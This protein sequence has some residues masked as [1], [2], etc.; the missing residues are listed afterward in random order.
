MSV[1]VPL[2]EIRRVRRLSGESEGSVF[3]DLDFQEALE[4]YPL[5]DSSGVD[6][7][8]ADWL[9][10]WDVFA[11]AADIWDEKSAA[12]SGDFDFSAD[13]ASYSRSQAYQNAVSQA[14]SMRARASAKSVTIKI[15][16][17]IETF[18][19]WIANSAEVES[20]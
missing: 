10:R 6:P 19:T 2:S 15:D 14:K 7:S 1:A 3:S 4:R 8:E 13:G 20:T 17:P 12:L 9:G 5:T 16:P 18:E 11:A